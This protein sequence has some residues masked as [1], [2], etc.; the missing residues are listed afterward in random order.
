MYAP[1][2]IG[3][4]A[5]ASS[6]T[7]NFPRFTNTYSFRGVRHDLDMHFAVPR[8]I[9]TRKENPLPA[10]QRQLAISDPY[11]RRRSHHR[12]LNVRIRI[13]LSVRRSAH[14]RHYPVDSGFHLV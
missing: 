11:R 6:L 10:A 13:P 12:R 4:N 9:E 8:P 3:L 14:G 7:S 5:A 2:F 1:I